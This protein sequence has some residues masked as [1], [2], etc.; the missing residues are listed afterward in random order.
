M[1]S[2]HQRPQLY[3]CTRDGPAPDIWHKHQ[4]IL[5]PVC[6]Q[7]SLDR[8]QVSTHLALGVCNPLMATDT[9]CTGRIIDGDQALRTQKLL[10]FFLLHWH[11][12][13]CTAAARLRGG[14][15]N[16]PP[17]AARPAGPTAGCQDERARPASDTRKA[18]SHSSSEVRLPMHSTSR[19]VHHISSLAKSCSCQCLSKLLM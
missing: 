10:W 9:P 12:C 13:P 3:L 17:T 5:P 4:L 11:C 14:R 18:C 6:C 16:S 2:K 8:V 1:S 15:E 7:G 19:R